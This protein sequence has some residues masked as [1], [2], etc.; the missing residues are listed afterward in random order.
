M[1]IDLLPGDCTTTV[2]PLLASCMIAFQHTAFS[3]RWNPLELLKHPQRLPKK[4]NILFVLFLCTFL[5]SVTLN[6]LWFHTAGVSIR[7]GS[8]LF[9]PI[10]LLRWI[11]E[12]IWISNA[13]LIT[14]LDP[15]RTNEAFPGT[16]R[17]LL[18]PSDVESQT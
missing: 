9:V 11:K 8:A 3:E 18:P 15:R 14:S 6:Q 12:E 13:T 17:F 2:H 10:S 4:N 16:G 5:H 1:T 7:E